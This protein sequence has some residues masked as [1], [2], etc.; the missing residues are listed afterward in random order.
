LGYIQPVK[1]IIAHIQRI[2][3]VTTISTVI[4]VSV[5]DDDT[6]VLA[7]PPREP[8]VDLAIPVKEQNQETEAD[9]I[10]P[11]ANPAVPAISAQG[12]API[13]AAANPNPS[14]EL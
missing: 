14:Q 1:K 4:D 12:S 2:V 5:S 8:S 9:S 10:A 6:N 11:S 13:S 3:T 7:I